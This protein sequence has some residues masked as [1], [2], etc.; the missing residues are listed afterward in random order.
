MI[1]EQRP[2]NFTNGHFWLEVALAGSATGPAEI[3]TDCSRSCIP[4]LRPIMIAGSICIPAGTCLL[5][6]LTSSSS[7]S[8]AG[9]GSLVM[10]FGMGL[11]NISALILTQG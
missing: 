2:S 11:I 1:K 7:A 5:V 3:G 9:A 4:F 6:L 8:L 10:G